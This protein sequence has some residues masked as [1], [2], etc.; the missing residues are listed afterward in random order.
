LYRDAYSHAERRWN[1]V[2]CT[3]RRTNSNLLAEQQGESSWSRTKCTSIASTV[4]QT[5]FSSKFFYNKFKKFI[6]SS[7]ETRSVTV[8]RKT[9]SRNVA[10]YVR[11]GNT[12]GWIHK[13][14]IALWHG[15]RWYT[16]TTVLYLLLSI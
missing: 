1:S 14:S 7:K 4:N 2:C 6:L 5:L 10:V 12:T 11:I 9:F 13:K 16:I 3:D 15:G 8:S